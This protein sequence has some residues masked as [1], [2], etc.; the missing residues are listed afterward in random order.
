MHCYCKDINRGKLYKN[1]ILFLNWQKVVQDKPNQ[2][3]ELR[4]RKMKD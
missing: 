2:R 1:D 3:M 4:S